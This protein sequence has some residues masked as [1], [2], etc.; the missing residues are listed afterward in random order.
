MKSAMARRSALGVTRV[1]GV[2]PKGE[3]F[4]ALKDIGGLVVPVGGPVYLDPL[5]FEEGRDAG[6]AL[7]PVLGEIGGGRMAPAAKREV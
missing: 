1:I 6:R 4:G 3:W 2:D 7:P 5:S